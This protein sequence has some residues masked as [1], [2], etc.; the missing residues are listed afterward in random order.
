MQ[1][2]NSRSTTYDVLVNSY[3]NSVAL[4]SLSDKWKCAVDYF[5][6]RDNGNKKA[7][8]NCLKM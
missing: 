2:S 1:Y 8:V 4:Y 5:A 6:L 7:G 3:I